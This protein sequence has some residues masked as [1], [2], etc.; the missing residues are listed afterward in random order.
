MPRSVKYALPFV[1][2]MM[3]VLYI[4]FIPEDPLAIKLLFKLIPMW[5]IL[6]YGFLQFQAKKRPVHWLLLAGLFFCMLGD[7]LLVWF[8]VG[9]TAFLIGHLF[10]LSAFISQ[11]RYS[12]IRMISLLPIGCYAWFMGHRLVESLQLSGDDALILPVLA[13]VTVISLMLWSALMTGNLIAGIGSL[14]FVISD[15]ILSWNMFISP[16]SYS[17]VLI[18]TTYYSA[19]FLIAISIGSLGER[20]NSIGL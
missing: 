15:S 17:G 19:Q 10:Y 9:L 18:M 7:G 3:S 20:R 14:L 8:V 11:W 4:F 2:L 16:V 6:L 5:L 1:I 13:Y 12:P